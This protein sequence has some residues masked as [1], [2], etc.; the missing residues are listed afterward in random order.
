MNKAYCPSCNEYVEYSIR[1]NIIKEYKGKEV[2]VI[3]NIAQCK[4]CGTDIFVNEIEEENLKRLYS[5]YRKVAELIT[6][7]EIMKLRK[8]YN[9]S[10][11]ELGEI[12]GWGK[13][14]VNRYERG[15]LPSQSHSD[16]LKL[17]I[18]NEE[19]FKEK[20]DE[21]FI[22][23]RIREKTYQ[24]IANKFSDTIAKMKR[25]ILNKSLTHEESIYNGFRKFDFDKLENLISYI[26]DKVDNLYQTSLNKIL[27][28]IDF[29]YFKRYLRSITGLRYMKYEHGPVIENFMYRD[30]IDYPSEKYTVIEKETSE[31][32]TIIIIK[33]NKNYDLTIFSKNELEVINNVINKLKNETCNSLSKLSHQEKAWIE[34]P[35]KSLITYEYANDIRL[36]I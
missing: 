7:E 25:K 9:L 1:Q 4:K 10:Q 11:R 16:Y 2:N 17:M 20:V 21:A 27:F 24:K 3:E 31:G 6:P 33:S 13:M 34:I 5:K 19:I 28:Y 18:K 14:T 23:K 12:L 35:I 36:F 15:S 29:T 22:N 26:A 32:A 8:K 30:I